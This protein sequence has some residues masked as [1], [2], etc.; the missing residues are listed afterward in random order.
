MARGVLLIFLLVPSFLFSSMLI[1]AESMSQK[2]ASEIAKLPSP[3]FVP[4]TKE[5]LEETN[6]WLSIDIHKVNSYPEDA[7][8]LLSNDV[9][10]RTLQTL[11]INGLHLGALKDGGK[12]RTQL[13]IDP[14]WSHAWPNIVAAAQAR[15]IALIGD[16]I[17][18]ATGTGPDF[19]QALQKNPAYAD[20][21][22]LVE[23]DPK[24]WKYLPPIPVGLKMANIPWLSL[25]ELEKKGYVPIETRPYIRDSAWNATAKIRDADGIERRWIY[26]KENQNDP[27]L[28]WLSSTFA[29]A[30]ILAA[31][32]LDSIYRMDQKILSLDVY[33]PLFAR[34]TAALWVRKIG[35]FTIQKTNGTFS[36]LKAGYLSDAL[37]DTP[38]RPA[39]LH[40]LLAE[41]TRAIRLI[42][43]LYLQE[44]IDIKRLVHVL[45]PFDQYACDWT[46]FLSN[47]KKYY[48]YNEE[49][50]S[51]ELLRSRLLEEDI[52]RIQ[53]NQFD[54]LP[55]STWG[56]YCA[57]ASKI[58]NPKDFSNSREDIQRA[59]LLLAFFYA[60]QPGFFSFSAADLTGALPD[61]FPIDFLGKNENTLYPSLL[62]QIQTS[63]SFA[64]QLAKMLSVR[65]S[66][67]IAAG[68]L[69]AI[70]P[71]NHRSVM[72]LLHQLPESGF[73]HLTA[74]NFSRKA[75][76]ERI[77][78]PGIQDTWAIDLM[79]GLSQKKEFASQS[80][81]FDLPPLS[82][83]VFL[84]QP[85]YY[86]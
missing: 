54:R 79:S 34:E 18:N 36:D 22:Q 7:L 9:F 14:Q 13:S 83:K 75:V 30:R 27:V 24:D 25:E 56:G 17:G 38:T 80:F 31:D 63:A 10:W 53:E 71:S 3:P 86:N 12:A 51:G 26:L 28:S 29:S 62:L 52:L 35:G 74:V 45:E 82:G 84:F 37:I 8:A 41:D 73:L 67:R 20:L 44:D 78:V 32:A 33:L 40:A 81:F 23:I 2:Y 61:S 42:Y 58:A 70:P 49:K 48:R 59:H 4:R 65:K 57:I 11:G 6:I 76:Q 15:G 43:Q 46:E 69:I 39:L 55:V 66:S 1:D 19:E 72:M 47:S 77:E 50:I 5:L 21:Y 68:Q 64:S 85:K 60:M 16:L